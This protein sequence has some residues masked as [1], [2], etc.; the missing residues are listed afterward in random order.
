MP[1]VMSQS[2]W[3]GASLCRAGI[4]IVPA[5]RTKILHLEGGRASDTLPAAG[6]S[7]PMPRAD[8]LSIGPDIYWLLGH[9]D[10]AA[11]LVS[12]FAACLDVTDAWAGL[13]I[14]G[15]NATA[16]LAKGT[17][18]D[19]HPRAF[20]ERRCAVTGFAQLRAVLWRPGEELDYDLYV[21]RSYASSLWD[22]LAYA[23]AEYE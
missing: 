1:S 2:P 18:V 21:G 5:G 14:S 6:Y 9:P 20:P 11:S 4:K 12:S 13:R 19:L 23:V 7:T 8:L 22:W 10:D 17:A 15:P 16:V 3:P